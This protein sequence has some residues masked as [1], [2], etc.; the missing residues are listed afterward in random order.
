MPQLN[1]NAEMNLRHGSAVQNS[2]N[3]YRKEESLTAASPTLDQFGCF[4]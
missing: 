1:V 4:K 2:I 3:T